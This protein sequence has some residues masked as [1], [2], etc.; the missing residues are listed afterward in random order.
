MATGFVQVS[1]DSTGK[2]LQT[3][4]NTIGADSVHSE[5]VTWVGT[6]GL[7]INPATGTQSSVASSAS[8]VTLLAAN[9]A[10]K[11]ASIFN[12]STTNLFVKFGA[13]ASTTSFAVKMIPFSY[14][15]LEFPCYTG[16]ID[17][18]W[19]TANGSARVNEM[20]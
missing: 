5:A 18:I 19:D 6:D 16:I 12:D 9:A 20:T 4:N 13:T 7:S 15:E 8:N 10:R 2:K 3:F 17:G 14:F 1:P 11:G